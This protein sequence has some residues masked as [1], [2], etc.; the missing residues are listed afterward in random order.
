MVCFRTGHAKFF[1]YLTDITQS[2]NNQ[3]IKIRLHVN[4]KLWNKI[5]LTKINKTKSVTKSSSELNCKSFQ[6]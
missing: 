5:N 3:Y 1:I 2:V 6:K 4:N